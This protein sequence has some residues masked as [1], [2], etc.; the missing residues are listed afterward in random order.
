MDSQSLSRRSFL[1]R[2]GIAGAGLIATGSVVNEAAASAFLQGKTAS[3]I[4][5]AGV[6]PGL[7][8]LDQGENA[9]GPSPM[10]VEAVKGHLLEMNRYLN[11]PPPELYRKLNLMS[12]VSYEGLDL[13]NPSQEEGQEIYRRNRVMVTSGGS[14][15]LLRATTF[16][17]LERG[18]HVIESAGGY[19]D[20]SGFANALQQR[21]RNVTITRV[22]LRADMNQDLPATLDAINEET[23]LIAITNPNNPTETIISH[24]D[25]TDFVDKVP[26]SVL[27][28]IDE[29]YIDFVRQP[30][31][32]NALSL[33]ISR[34]NVIVLRTFSKAYGLSGIRT[35]YGVSHPSNF[36]NLY[37]Y[38]DRWL[39][40]LSAYAAT[41]ALDDHEH[42]ANTRRLVGAGYSYL[43]RELDA[44]GMQYVPS[45]SNFV[46]INVGKDPNGIINYLRGKNVL[47]RNA[48]WMGV[49]NHIRV[50]IGTQDELEV[51][52]ST[53]KEALSPPVN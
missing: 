18:G 42:I 47:I 9:L 7:V 3:D 25:F 20:V 31:Y 46:S 2:A 23:K 17:S 40:T 15:S 33:A 38:T 28:L 16:A 6:P 43:T 51:F 39:P 44:M 32:Q 37:L 49:K 41:A 21:G 14:T 13:E 45:E 26:E 53:F 52:I 8:D 12:G 29:A 1:R 30:N 11:N 22:P 24:Q 35:G 48:E 5:G 36:N 19:G 4:T 10:A 27:V 50:T 34:P